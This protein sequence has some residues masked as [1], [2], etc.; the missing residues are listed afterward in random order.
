MPV[1]SIKKT[2]QSSL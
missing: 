1:D 2:G